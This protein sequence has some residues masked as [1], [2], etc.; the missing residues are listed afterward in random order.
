MITAQKELVFENMSIY[1]LK[2]EENKIYVGRSKKT[3]EKGVKARITQHFKNGSTCAAWCK[4]YNPIDIIDIKYNQTKHD[5]NKWVKIYMEKYGIENVRGGDYVRVQLPAEQVTMLRNELKGANDQCYKCGMTGH[6]I[7]FCPEEESSDL[8]T[9]WACN[10]CNKEYEL[11]TDCEICELKHSHNIIL[12][13]LCRR[14]TTFHHR[15]ISNLCEQ[16]NYHGGHVAAALRKKEKVILN[17]NRSTVPIKK[18]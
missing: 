11:E 13:N 8:Y 9:V 14:F 3:T 15:I 16:L 12:R 1:M 18:V 17:F 5:E 7:R 2:L 4:K 10:I 6:F